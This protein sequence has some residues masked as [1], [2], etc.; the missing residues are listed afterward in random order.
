VC[1][2]EL[3][4]PAARVAVRAAAAQCG[5]AGAGQREGG[6]AAGKA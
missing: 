1:E 3:V 6:K 2:Q 4:M 5:E